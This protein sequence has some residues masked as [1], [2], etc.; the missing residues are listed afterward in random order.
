MRGIFATDL[1]WPRH[2]KQSVKV[3]K[4]FIKDFK[5]DIF[6]MGGDWMNMDSMNHWIENR[7]VALA[8]SSIK[9]EFDGFNS[10]LDKFF[11]GFPKK[12]KKVF[13]IGNHEQWAND[14]RLANPKFKGYLEIESNLRFKERKIKVVKFN[15]VF[16]LGKMNFIHGYYTND[17]HTKKMCQNYRKSVFYGHTHDVQSW[18]HVSPID[19]R[20]YHTSQSVGCLCNMNMTYMKNKPNRWVHG[21]LAFYV[22]PRDRTFSA[23]QIRIPDGKFTWNEK[24]YR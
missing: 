14:Y 15:E 13:M 1:H 7:D 24:V 3:L 18:T 6:I 5:P 10:F 11:K 16:R 23:Y 22:H 4:Q 17:N 8:N 19:Q 20:D 21:F 2:D 9:E 12:C